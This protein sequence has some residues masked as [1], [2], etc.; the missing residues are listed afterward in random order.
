MIVNQ[1]VRCA[2]PACAGRRGDFFVLPQGG[3]RQAAAAVRAAQPSCS[4]P[5]DAESPVTNA[6][7]PETTVFLL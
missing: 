2:A 1:D 6:A 5:R 4:A 7:W 3:S